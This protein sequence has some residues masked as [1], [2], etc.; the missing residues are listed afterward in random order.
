M[1]VAELVFRTCTNVETFID[2]GLNIH[3]DS[4]HDRARRNMNCEMSPSLGKYL[5]RDFDRN[6]TLIL[7][8]DF[9]RSTPDS[10]LNQYE[11]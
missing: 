2:N 7:I 3:S 11:N 9:A 10:D 6:V 5:K 1:A 8:G 4:N